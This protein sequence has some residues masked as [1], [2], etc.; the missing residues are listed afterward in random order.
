MAKQ[1]QY[2]EEARRSLEAGVNQ[3]A[4]TVK[5]TLGPKGR[6]VVLDKKFGS[7][8]ITNDGVTIAKRNRARRPV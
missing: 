1:I 6:N 5:I 8:L 3:L 2:G 4:N 7:P